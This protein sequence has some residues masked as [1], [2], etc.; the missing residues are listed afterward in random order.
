[1]LASHLTT[2]DKVF[3]KQVEGEIITLKTPATITHTWTNGPLITIL[4]IRGYVEL[5]SNEEVRTA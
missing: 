4:T 1:M 3:I 5:D 2:G